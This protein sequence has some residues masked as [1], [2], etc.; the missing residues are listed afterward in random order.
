MDKGLD[1]LIARIKKS[2][3]RNKEIML[4]FQEYCFAQ[5]LS[6]GRIKK[7]LYTLI[8][9]SQFLGKKF[10]KANKKDIVAVLAKLE[11]SDY[12]E[13]T[14]RD[15]KI[16]LKKLYAWIRN[17]D[18][19]TYPPEV[20]FFTTALKRNKE[21]VREVLTEEEIK[22][23]I[24]SASTVRDKALLNC[25]WQSGCRVGELL[26]MKR[27][28]VAF[29]EYSPIIT[30]KG[31]SGVRKVRIMDKENFLKSWVDSLPTD[32]NAIWI[33][34][35]NRMNGSDKTLSMTEAAVNKLL[36][37]VGKKCNIQKNIYPHL[38]RASR[39]TFLASLMKEQQIKKMFGWVQSSEMLDVYISQNDVVLDE[40]ILKMNG[41]LENKEEEVQTKIVLNA[42]S[43]LIKR[44]PKFV[45]DSFKRMKKLG[46][47]REKKV[48]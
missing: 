38:I 18:P 21:K 11:K 31:K 36:K 2:T 29:D 35:F 4:K 7:Y 12:E 19:K 48:I 39:A 10:E 6:E 5:G 44:D 45:S 22:K 33:T 28:D 27:S 43:E 25:L 37:T 8:K 24:Q 15:F 3:D 17:C 23:M 9:L 30:L 47:V 13:Q 32:Q 26:S 46:I 40:A 14:K 1:R 34:N 41:L 16:A 42:Y 20:S